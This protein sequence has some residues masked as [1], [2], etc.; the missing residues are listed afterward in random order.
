HNSSTVLLPKSHIF[1]DFDTNLSLQIQ[2]NND[3]NNNNN[4]NNNNN[5]QNVESIQH[6]ND[7]LVNVSISYFVQDSNIPWSPCDSTCSNESNNC[8]AL[9]NRE[10]KQCSS[11]TDDD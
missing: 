5:I 4:D 6:N 3:N 9:Y 1:E 8:Y 7:S 2:N 11:S 10:I